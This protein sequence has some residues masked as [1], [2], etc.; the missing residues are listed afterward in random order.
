M[1]TLCKKEWQQYFSSLTGI[2]SIIVFLLLNGLLLFVFPETDILGFGYATLGTFFSYSPYILLF[3]VPSV[4]MRSFA[5]EYRSGTF[6]LLRTLPFSSWE[7]VFGKF[8]GCLLIMSAAL[9]PT[10]AYMA[11]L[12]ALSLSGGID[13]G[14]A[15]G[16]YIGLLLLGSAYTAIGLCA[17][18]FKDNTVVA[19]VTG[20]FCCFLM[21]HA[22]AAI[23]KLQIFR[24][25]EIG[26]FIET[27]GIDF[28]YKSLSKGVIDGRDILYFIG[29]CS[30]ALVISNNNVSKK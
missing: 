24:S 17:S 18:S 20:S 25:N 30:V 21:F 9:L 23:G 22:P 6:E 29:I 15:V 14:A 4:T 27:F 13:I 2:L 12:N 8:L 7:I 3:L 28:H 26:Y 5:E 19:F 1:W 11:S 10:L 16:S